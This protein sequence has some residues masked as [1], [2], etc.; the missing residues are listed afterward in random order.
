MR[1]S[2][3]ESVST[4][5]QFQKIVGA[6]VTI[7]F[8]EPLSQQVFESWIR[9]LSNRTNRFGLCVNPIRLGPTKA[10]IYGVDCRLW[11]PLF[12]EITK[13]GCVAIVPNDTGDVVRRLIMNIQQYIDPEAEAF[14]GDKPYETRMCSDSQKER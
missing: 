4:P 3:R 2:I 8:R 12:L 1:N 5:G 13:N 7:R 10:H 9:E 11:K 6:P 14:I